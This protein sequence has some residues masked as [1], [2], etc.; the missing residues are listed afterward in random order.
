MERSSQDVAILA[1]KID[2][3]NF[4]SEGAGTIEADG[5]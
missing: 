2:R 3:R 5:L 4:Y 1:Y